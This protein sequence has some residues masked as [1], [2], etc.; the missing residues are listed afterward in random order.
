MHYLDHSNI[1][2]TNMNSCTMQAADSFV[3]Y[4]VYYQHTILEKH[5]R[6][7]PFASTNITCNLFL[8]DFFALNLMRPLINTGENAMNRLL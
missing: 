7:V 5:G 6:H 1:D 4:I 8:N 3:L 2:P